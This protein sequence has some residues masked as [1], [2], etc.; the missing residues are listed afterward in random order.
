MWFE[1]LECNKCNNKL[2][3][4]YADKNVK[5]KKC[6]KDFE[7]ETNDTSYA[8][9]GTGSSEFYKFREDNP[10][11]IERRYFLNQ[12]LDT[13]EEAYQDTI[14]LDERDEIAAHL[15][16]VVKEY[17]DA[18]RMRLQRLLT[19]DHITALSNA[20]KEIISRNPYGSTV[21]L[22]RLL[23]YLRQAFPSNSNEIDA[24]LSSHD[25]MIK[26]VMWIRHK[27][28]HPIYTLWKTP[29]NIY[30]DLR[31]D[32]DS[33]NTPDDILNYDFLVRANNA[34]VD[35]YT[36]TLRL[37]PQVTDKWQ[38]ARAEYFRVKK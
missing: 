12:P 15:V 6:G 26:K 3:I 5:C 9:G 29:A 8:I 25:S 17:H 19:L 22:K 38:L 13:L 32:V 37:D 4:G 14:A 20:E 1:D 28:E 7:I 24:I 30:E 31:E 11:I 23:V 18:L 34:V 16:P 36:L 21:N 27:S 33:N 2:E 35:I 10:E